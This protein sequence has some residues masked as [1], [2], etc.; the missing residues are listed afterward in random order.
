MR[1][2]GTTVAGDKGGFQFQV[3]VGFLILCRKLHRLFTDER[4]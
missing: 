2:I 1:P 4:L 3:G